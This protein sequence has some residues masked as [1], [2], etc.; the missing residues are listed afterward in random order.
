MQGHKNPVDPVKLKT[1]STPFTLLLSHTGPPTHGQGIASKTA[2]FLKYQSLTLAAV[3]LSSRS[4]AFKSLFISSS[5][6]AC[7][8]E[9]IS[10]D[11]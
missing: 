9:N 5:K 8:T 2:T 1:G 7:R 6:R 11:L 3:M 10:H 4:C